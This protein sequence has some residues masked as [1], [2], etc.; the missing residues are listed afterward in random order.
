[1]AR[2]TEKTPDQLS[3]AQRRV[4]DEIAKGPRGSV[5]GPFVPLLGSPGLADHVQKLGAYIRYESKLPGK[6]REFAI[7][8][9][10][11]HWGARY[12]WAAHVPIALKEGLAQATI[13]AI[14]DRRQP[15][16]TDP[17]EATV[18]RFCTAL[19]NHHNSDDR[20][21]GEAK[22]LLG[23][24]RLVDLIGLMGYYTIIALTLNTF[25]VPIPPGAPVLKD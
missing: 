23:E 11:R 6:L 18:H 13:D 22:E 12:E 25:E 24:E 2:F 3:P 7:L 21:F 9:T 1:M 15:A 4:H 10:A 8:M 5:R 19:I 16:L 17:A 20:T 14:N